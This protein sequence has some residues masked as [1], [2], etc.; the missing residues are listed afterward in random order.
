MKTKINLLLVLISMTSCSQE[1][2]LSNQ[3]SLD[4]ILSQPLGEVPENLYLFETI[5]PSSD[6]PPFTKKLTVCGITLV[7]R[8]EISDSFMKDVAQTVADMFTVDNRID[9]AMQEKLLTNLYLYRAVIPIFAG[10]N[11]S[12]SQKEEQLI[13]Q[14]RAQN[15]VCDIIMEGVDGQVVEVVEHILHHI[16]NVGFHHTLPT[17][18]GLSDSSRLYEMAQ[19]AIA[20]GYFDINDYSEIKA[21]GERNRVI[22]QEYAYWIIYTMWNLRKTYGPRESEWSIQT[23]EELESKLPESSQFVKATIEKII[24]CPREGTLR[25]FIQ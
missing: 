14:T 15:S 11:W 6:Y 16:S 4:C 2:M 5:Q 18:W 20:S 25:S 24:R 21:V 3:V 1:T 12:L 8:A 7:A 9:V 22:L 13:G 23:A 19:Q 10:E 17:E